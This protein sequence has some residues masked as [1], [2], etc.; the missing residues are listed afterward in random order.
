MKYLIRFEK[1]KI[2]E[3]EAEDCFEAECKAKQ[4]TDD[5]IE[6]YAIN[7]IN[8]KRYRMVDRPSENGY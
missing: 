6:K 1:T 8:N 7:S 2:V 4:L 5:Y 3:I